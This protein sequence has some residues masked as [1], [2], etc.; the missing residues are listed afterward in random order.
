MSWTKWGALLA[1]ALAACAKV[2]TPEEALDAG[3]EPGI[4]AVEP[5]PGPVPAD[6]RFTVRF[7]TP[8]D[9]GQLLAASG[10]S[11]T[12]V[13]ALDADVERAAAAIEHAQL[14]AHERTL[15]LAAQA[16]IAADR[17]SIALAPDQPLPA[18]KLWLLLS[19]R[20][21]DESGRRLAATGARYGFEVASAAPAKAALVFPA[22]GSE[23]PSNLL[24]VRAS[25]G[26]GRL[27][28]VGPGGAEAGAADARGD[29]LLPLGAP[30]TPGAQY[31]LALDGAADPA[32]S[33]TAGACAR[34]SAP[35]IEGGA[36]QLSARDNAVAVGL[37]LDWPARVEVRIGNAAD[38]E[39]CSGPCTASAAY[40]PCPVKACGPQS[41]SCRLALRIE[42]LQPAH[43]YALRVI[44]QDDLGHQSR[45]PLQPFSTAAPLPRLII[46]EVMAAPP[47]PQGEAEYA[48]I[49]NLGPGAA[50][51]DSLA[52]LSAD[53]ISRPLLAAPPP[54]PVQL[55]PGGRAL[56]VG[57]SFNPA[58]Y[59]S[60]P[61]GT[62][63]LRASTQR[64]LGR[65]LADAAPPD[66]RLMLGTV[67]L[68]RFPGGGPSCPAGSSL[69]RDESAPPQGSAA[70]TCGA[71]GGTP[72][73]PP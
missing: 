32:Q 11:E 64:L 55:A 66:F 51:L 33:F 1:A 69:Q 48:E 4:A 17:R 28:L 37:T 30:L 13:L 44:A 8:M 6:A 54:N 29:V 7:A 21:K 67:E 45:G 31:A 41:F 47:S 46:S 15:L 50:V 19:P 26:S 61:P 18:G 70:W 52:L 62:P 34:D 58:R 20:L 36:A 72:G 73:L 23:A 59:P 25:A 2:N 63:V 10:R 9:E 22:A 3:P 57:S 49:L 38:G 27:A 40:V 60:L 24:A 43:D 68:A 5:Q 35:A 56:A 53:G 16:E 71:V 42:G 14:S 65:G 12:V 39:P